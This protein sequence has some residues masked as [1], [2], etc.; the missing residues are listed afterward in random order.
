M[1]RRTLYIPLLLA[2]AC[3]EGST[4]PPFGDD[5]TAGDDD[6]P[7]AA[8]PDAA[9]DDALDDDAADA[10]NPP[11][12]ENPSP[13]ACQP[14]DPSAFEP[15]TPSPRISIGKPVVTSP[16]VENPDGLVDGDYRDSATNTRFGDVTEDALAFAAIDLG[17][18]PSRLFVLWHDAS[19]LRY[20]EP[21]QGSPGA[22]RIEVSADSSDGEDGEWVVAEEVTDNRVRARGHLVDFEGMRWLRFVFLALTD[23]STRRE[24]NLDEIAVHDVSA[25][26][27]DAVDAWFFLGDSI[28][29]GAFKR[30]IP[31]AQTFDE[32]VAELAPSRFPALVNG[33]IGGE[34]LS[35][36][37]A[38]I[39]QV[40][41]DYPHFRYVAVAFGTNDSW[42]NRSVAGAGFETRL[43]ELVEKIL[44]AGRVP[45]LARIPFAS[46]GAHETVP[47]FNA[48]ID[49]VREEYEL[50][51]GPDLHG[52]FWQ[53]PRDLGDDG[54]HPIQN[55][56]IAI[57]RLWAE[58]AAA[59]Y[60][61]D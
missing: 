58:A 8:P 45:V 31:E 5:D 26:E 23:D 27:G 59:H 16:G 52:W 22:Y 53:N 24:L 51:C 11:E 40:L 44:D 25:V 19:Y 38:R 10:G 29:Q 41:S 39:D 33:G 42:G 43:V 60:A 9:D 17:Q 21:A 2:C 7:D 3:A 1:L 37:L 36:A 47:E 18:G 46:D 4:P 57:H 15:A 54:V 12:P 30:D 6:A 61:S 55:G 56:N 20:N 32:L 48:V 34:L 13:P 14:G 35:D 49:R 28:T 50:P